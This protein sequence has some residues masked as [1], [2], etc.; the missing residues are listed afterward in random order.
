MAVPVDVVI[1]TPPRLTGNPAVDVNSL[2]EYTHLLFKQ[3]VIQGRVLDR[4]NAAAVLVPASTTFSNP[5]TTAECR[6]L[7]EK[8][9]E[10]ITALG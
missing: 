9:N 8:L 6:A 1:P 4:L 7:A 3:L 10:L 5:P 2:T